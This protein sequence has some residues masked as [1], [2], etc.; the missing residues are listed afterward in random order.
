MA[1]HGASAWQQHQQHSGINATIW[2]WQRAVP[3]STACQRQ[4]RRLEEQRRKRKHGAD[5]HQRNS[6]KRRSIMAH[7]YQQ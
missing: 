4:Q 1:W 2:A 7:Q 6:G 5:S 3:I